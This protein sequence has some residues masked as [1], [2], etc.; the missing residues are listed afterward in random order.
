MALTG[1]N[2]LDRLAEME[3][4]AFASWS[5]AQIAIRVAHTNGALRWAWKDDDPLFAYPFSV[6]S[7]TVA[8]TSGAIAANLLGEGTWC[9]LF[10]ADPRPANAEYRKIY[11]TVSQ[12]GVHPVTSET[13]VYAFYRAAVPQLTYAAASTYATPN[14]IPSILLDIVALRALSGLYVGMQQ[15]DAL[16]ALKS[17][18]GEPQDARDSLKNSLLNTAALPW[19]QHGLAIAPA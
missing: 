10:S 7:G 9:S 11:A 8:V 15:W 4:T 19:A 2:L 3:G 6:A 13:S 16:R 5:E 1:K 18:Y 14:D 17:V 12:S